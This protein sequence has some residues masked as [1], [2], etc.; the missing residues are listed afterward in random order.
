MVDHLKDEISARLPPLE[1]E[2]VVG[3][4]NVQEEFL[5]TGQGGKKVTTLFSN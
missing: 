4:A 3:R 5:I 2:D 1:I